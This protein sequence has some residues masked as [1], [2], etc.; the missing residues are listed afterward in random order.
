VKK[1]SADPDMITEL[2]KKQEELKHQLE[3]NSEDTSVSTMLSLKEETQQLDTTFQD[4]AYRKQHLSQKLTELE[5]TIKEQDSTLQTLKQTQETLTK[6]NKVYN[7]QVEDAQEQLETLQKENSDLLARMLSLKEEQMNQFNQLNDYYESILKRE[8][9]LE[10]YKPMLE[11]DISL[12]NE[13]SYKFSKP[14]S[15][16]DRTLNSFKAHNEEICSVAYNDGGSIVVTAGSENYLKV[17]DSSTGF[18]KNTL[19]GLGRGALDVCISPGTE[20][21]MAACLDNTAYVWNYATNRMRHNL[22]GHSGKVS[23]CCF[24]HNKALALTGSHDSTIKFWDIAKGY[25]SKT[26]ASFSSCNGVALSTEDSLCVSGHYDGHIRFWAQRT[27]EVV[28]DVGVSELSVTSL[29]FSPNN[30]TVAVVSRDNSVYLLDSR[31]FQVLG[32]L[33]NRRYEASASLMKISWSSDSRYLVSGSHS[34]EV[35]VWDTHT[36][37]VQEVLKGHS[38]PVIAVAWKP[39]ASGMVSVD[40]EG[41]MTIWG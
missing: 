40:T 2:Q 9:L 14:V 33:S 21:V 20:L 31:M 41:F 8:K 6:E 28:E 37:S 12:E 34:G 13:V 30:N 16:P 32:T 5:E 19:R 36:K 27:G 17:W 23:S 1:A 3:E 22:T 18:E 35:F 29:A 4:T 38:C 15:L 24:F 7:K 26:L 25:C 11:K 39:R 10:S